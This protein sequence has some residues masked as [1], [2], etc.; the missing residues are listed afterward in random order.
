MS[1]KPNTENTLY[2]GRTDE[3]LDEQ[4]FKFMDEKSLSMTQAEREHFIAEYRLLRDPGN[5]EIEL[6]KYPMAQFDLD[7]REAIGAIRDVF[8]EAALSKHIGNT[9]DRVR[10]GICMARVNGVPAPVLCRISETKD[11]QGAEDQ[12]IQA[13][14]V[15][16]F[17]PYVKTTTLDIA[18][19]NAAPVELDD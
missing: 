14:C 10:L 15:L 3:E 19:P 8:I 9:A 5:I 4:F 13:V 1:N 12:N 16:I 7:V 6:P 18:R 17:P 11:E 2:K